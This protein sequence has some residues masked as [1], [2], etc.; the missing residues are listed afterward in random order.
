M[1]RLAVI[2]AL[3]FGMS[4]FL[5][6]SAAASKPAPPPGCQFA[7]G[8][9]TCTTTTTTSELAPTQFGQGTIG[10]T[11][12]GSGAALLCAQQ[13]ASF[14]RLDTLFVAVLLTTT[15]TTVTGHHGAPNSNGSPIQPDT[16]TSTVA[17]IYAGQVS[18]F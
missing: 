15:T 5:A 14:Y 2:L 18:C 12:D 3:V 4:T 13:G 9:T 17:S 1:G 8:I 11:G 10:P 6:S 7:K 16:T